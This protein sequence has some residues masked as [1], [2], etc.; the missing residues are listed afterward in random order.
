MRSPSPQRDSGRRDNLGQTRVPGR[1]P[2][3][4]CS[5]CLE[6][7]PDHAQ[8]EVTARFVIVVSGIAIESW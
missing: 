6:H 1:R 3:I 8:P 2:E 7:S 5:P 4:S